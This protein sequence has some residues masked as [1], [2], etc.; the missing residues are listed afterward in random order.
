MRRFDGFEWARLSSKES[1]LPF[2]LWI[3]SFGCE[4]KGPPYVR[5]GVSSGRLIPV[6]VDRASP[7]ILSARVTG[8]DR[9]DIV[10]MIGFITAAYD[11]L[12]AHWNKWLLSDY[13]ALC[14][15]LELAQR[16]SG[17]SASIRDDEI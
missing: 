8:K 16:Q 15:L 12:I 13:D 14:F 2:D 4:Q 6:S 11:I 9:E 3:S 1:G 10:K 17:K 7:E 5:I